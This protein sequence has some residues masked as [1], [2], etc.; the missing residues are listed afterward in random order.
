MRRAQALALAAAFLLPAAGCQSIEKR[1]GMYYGMF[2]TQISFSAYT[3]SEEEF[4]TAEGA[5]VAEMQ[6]LNR[7][8]DIYAG[9]ANGLK[10]VNDSAGIAPVKVGEDI[11]DLVEFGIKACEKTGGAVNIAMGPVLKLWHEEREKAAEG[12][13]AQA[14][15]MKDLL[16]ARG[17]ADIEK[18]KVDRRLG[19]VFLEE[20]GMSLDVGAIAKGFS[21]ER[22]ASKVK[23]AGD[24]PF[25]IDAGGNVLCWGRPKNGHGLWRIGLEDPEG[26]AEGQGASF[27][28]VL[29]VTGASCVTSG[30]Y[31][32]YFYSGG[33]RYSHIIDPASLMPPER[34]ESVTIVCADS[35]VADM[36]STALFVLPLEEGKALAAAEGAEAIW[37]YAGGRHEETEGYKAYS[38]NSSGI[39]K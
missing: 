19:T 17:L 37:I 6:R 7:L 1:S 21:A 4:R 2:D 31:Q 25:I 16:K 22:A 15:A 13:A 10:A 20:K 8:F 27:F 28:D 39:W 11:L 33:R 29:R 24:W 32:R 9:D 12:K 38:E 26:G 3:K 36:L 5:F 34:F 14:P 30:S 35:G 23:E 18:V